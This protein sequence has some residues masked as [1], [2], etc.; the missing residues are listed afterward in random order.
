[1][2][3]I[4]DIVV[5]TEDNKNLF[6]VVLFN[7]YFDDIEYICTCKINSKRFGNK[8]AKN[9]LYIPY[10][11]FSDRKLC[12]VKLDSSFIFSSKEISNM[13][14]KLKPSIMLKLYE[15]LI[16]LDEKYTPLD[17]EHYEFIRNNINSLKHD[18]I[19]YEK[20]LIKENN[21]KIKQQRL[22]RKRNYRK[23]Q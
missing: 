4:G 2:Y 18:I 22:E 23:H 8:V 15:K 7:Y 11:I 1:M 5:K 20:K 19:E 14:I 16:S 21:R 6:Y 12:S 9:Y 13:M 17:K 10:Q 3:N